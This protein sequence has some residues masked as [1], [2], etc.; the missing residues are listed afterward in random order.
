[1]YMFTCTYIYIF[2]AILNK[3]LV[4]KSSSL[5]FVCALC[6]YMHAYK[7]MFYTIL[8]KP[9]VLK[10]SLL[11]LCVLYIYINVNMYIHV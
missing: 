8:N 10:P 9:L 6:I 5:V 11:T 2:D 1:M 7:Y 4:L 3:P